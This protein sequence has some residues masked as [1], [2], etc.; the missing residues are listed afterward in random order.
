M[1]YPSCPLI[2]TEFTLEDMKDN[3]TVVQ[4]AGV[5]GDLELCLEPK[6]N[7]YRQEFKGLKEQLS[8]EETF[9]FGGKI[10]L[11]S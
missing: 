8:K 2:F 4:R 9:A 3:V 7:P 6:E 10:G 5:K 1:S 11:R